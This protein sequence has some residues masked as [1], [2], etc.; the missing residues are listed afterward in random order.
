MKRTSYKLNDPDIVFVIN[1]L[2]RKAKTDI[3]SYV[4][5][6]EPESRIRIIPFSDTQKLDEFVYAFAERNEL[7][8]NYLAYKILNPIV[9]KDL[10]SVVEIST[11]DQ[12]VEFFGTIVSTSGET[13][14]S[15]SDVKEL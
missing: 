13:T 8:P 10:E 14:I 3:V 15:R 1:K 5:S 4:V 2:D 9:I 11:S 12:S 6:K 7:E